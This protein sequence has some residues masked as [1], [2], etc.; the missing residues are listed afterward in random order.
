[1][2]YKILAS[3]SSGNAVIIRDIILIDCGISFK[4]LQKY[5]KNLRIVLLTH[6]HS[7]RPLQK[8]NN[9]KTSTRKTNF[10]ICLL[11]MAIRTF[12]RMWSR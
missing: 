8:S 1:M 9:K 7:L 10:K 5:Y 11:R 3:C 6:I 4:R 12:I 2:E